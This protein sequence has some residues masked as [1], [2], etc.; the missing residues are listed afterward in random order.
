LSKKKKQIKKTQ[1]KQIAVS[2]LALAALPVC[3]IRL[4]LSHVVMR[5]KIGRLQEILQAQ[6][7]FDFALSK[8]KNTLT[9][10]TTICLTA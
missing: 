6:C 4:F 3:K 7:Q 9:R 10:Q 5:M 1:G 2:L 8:S